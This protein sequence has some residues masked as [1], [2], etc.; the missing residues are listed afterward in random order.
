M[1]LPEIDLPSP[2]LKGKM[3][4][5][6][7]IAARKSVRRFRPVSLSLDQLGQLLWAAQGM[8]HGRLRAAPSAGATY[9]LELMVATGSGTVPGL[10]AGVYHYNVEG[11]SLSLQRAGDLRQRLATAALGQECVA[12]AAV[13]VVV[14]ALMSRTAF[15]YGRRAERYINMEAGHVGQNV[16]LQA[17][18]LKLGTVMV[19]AFDDE[20][21]RVTLELDAPIRP[22]Y[23]MPVGTPA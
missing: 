6:E 17:I 12:T 14:C 13:V 19:G 11:H 4:L 5:E 7:A 1:A 20:E 2:A 21:V 8:T 15:R 23:I 10:T 16:S 9:P 3:S 22:L 18:A